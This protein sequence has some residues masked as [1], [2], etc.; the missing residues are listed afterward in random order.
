MFKIVLFLFTFLTFSTPVQ[1]A[2]IHQGDAL[3]Y[4]FLITTQNEQN[5]WL[6]QQNEEAFELIETPENEGSLHAYQELVLASEEIVFTSFFQIIVSLLLLS[7][8]I[9]L[10]IKRPRLIISPLPLIIGIICLLFAQNFLT[11]LDT[12]QINTDNLRYYF[13]VLTT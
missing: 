2:V 9:I 8:T 4:T 1:G 6:L 11:Q 13:L 7:S 12:L 3:N 10:C 5:I